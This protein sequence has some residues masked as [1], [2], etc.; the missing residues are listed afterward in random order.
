MSLLD[1]ACGPG[2]VSTAVKELGAVPIGIDFS[3]KMISIAKRMLPDTSFI[4]S[5]AQDLPFP[6]ATFD[7]VL[8]N[9]GLLH[10]SHPERACAEACRVLKPNG[11]LGFSVWAR[12]EKNPGSPALFIRR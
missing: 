12:P 10:V 1:V 6:D 7:R 2:Y 3:E 5:D 9:F 11:R 4:Q 8:I